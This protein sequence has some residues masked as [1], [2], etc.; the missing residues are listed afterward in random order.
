VRQL[1]LL[2]VLLPAASG[3]QTTTANVEVEPVT[4]WWRTGVS[5]VRIGEP[6]SVLLTCSL[7]ETDAVRA[8]VDRSQLAAAAVQ[9]PPYEV[10]TGSEAPD[11]VTAGRRFIQ[12][13]YSLRLI[14]EDAFGG[15]VTIPPMEIDYHVESRV[16]QDA[17][18]QGREQKYVLPALPMRVVSLVPDNATYIREAPVPT[19]REIVAREFR[20]RMLRLVAT[21][22]FAVAGLMLAVA[23]VRWARRRGAVSGDSARRLLPHR[24]VIAGARREL[25]D[26]QQ[27]ARTVGWTAENVARALAATRVIASYAAGRPV[28]QRP[29]T[30]AAPVDGEL[31]LGGRFGPRVAVSGA[32]TAGAL[33]DGMHR[34]LHDALAQLT[35]ARYGR[36]NV[37]D[38]AS[39]DEAVRS[40]LRTAE[41]VASAHT[42]LNKTTAS[43]R[44]SA[45]GWRPRAWAR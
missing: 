3:A 41:R 18:V 23:L 29:M 1:L 27:S 38:E 45:R 10:L 42:W 6:F 4:C 19:L 22:L 14:V 26:V 17:A 20:A 9:F 8:V 36:A 16:Q 31:V 28:S 5:A 44:A 2:L 15:G 40:S 39:L 21:I 7:L 35:S 34:E 25:G 33:S 37:P 43:L 11:H 12:Y 30:Q 24:S 32:A 13:D